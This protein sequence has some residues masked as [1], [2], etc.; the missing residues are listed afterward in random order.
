MRI[1]VRV[2]SNNPSGGIKVANQ[3]V[4]LF[5]QR[6]IESF[7]VVNGEPH[8]ADWMIAPAPVISAEDLMKTCKTNDIVIDNWIDRYTIETTK[9]LNAEIKIYYSQGSTFYK[10]KDLIGDEHLKTGE[11]YTHYW[12]VS[13]DAQKILESKYPKT[14]RWH[15]VYPYF[16]HHVISSVREDVKQKENAIL[17]LARKGKSYIF[18]AKA[19]FGREIKFDIIDRK[20][21]EIEAYRLM[22]K[23]KF[24][25]S[26][27]VGVSPQLTWNMVKL[28]T[29]RKRLKVINPYR[30]GFPLPPTEAAACGSISIGFAM[31]GGL[32][33][34]SPST[35]FLAKDK[36]YLSLMRKIKEALSA[37]DE[38]LNTMRESAFK[39]VSEFNKEHTWKQVKSFLEETA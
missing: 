31:G 20:F 11:I 37:P 38:Q 15:L 18:L 17:C 12:A 16:E 28:L 9:K 7:L 13:T 2:P 34:M 36:S 29:G 3:L 1:F 6:G 19:L 27:A 10:S 25:L 22:A 32:E 8:V 33:W 35:C 14:E 4:S 39:A 26:T 21:T 30:E 5:R 23:Y 24:F